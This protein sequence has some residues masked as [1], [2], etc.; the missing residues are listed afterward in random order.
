MDMSPQEKNLFKIQ[1][2]HGDKLKNLF[3]M[4]KKKKYEDHYMIIKTTS[5]FNNSSLVK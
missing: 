2:F 1:N 3:V 4:F 5:M